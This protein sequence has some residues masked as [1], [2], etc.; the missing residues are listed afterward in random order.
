MRC[1]PSMLVCLFMLP[2]FRSCVSSHIDE[3]EIAKHWELLKWRAG[4]RA[5]SYPTTRVDKCDIL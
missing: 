1:P 2:L 3:I 4:S 5:E